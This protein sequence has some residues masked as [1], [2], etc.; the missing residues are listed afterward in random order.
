MTELFN[1]ENS[2]VH[3]ESFGQNTVDF[4]CFYTSRFQ[5]LFADFRPILTLLTDITCFQRIN[6]PSMIHLE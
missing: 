6:Q 4:H 1:F 5:K 2:S 3:L